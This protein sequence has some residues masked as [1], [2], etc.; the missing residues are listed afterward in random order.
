MEE[1]VAQVKGLLVAIPTPFDEND[2][3]DFDY[4]ARHLGFLRER[5]ADGVV[6]SGTNGEAAS[7]SLE[8][9]KRIIEVVAQHKGSLAAVAGT[10]CSSLVETIELTRAAEDSGADAAMVVPPFFFRNATVDG[11]YDY[12]AAVL[13]STA[14]PVYL[15]NIPALSGIEIREELVIRLLGF[16]NLAGI[17]DSGGD[18]ARTRRYI[19]AFPSL[20]IFYGADRIIEA[21]AGSGARGSISGIA[22][23]FPELISEAMTRC[24]AGTGTTLQERVN[25]LTYILDRY[26]LFAANKFVLSL[27]GFAY[28]RVRPPL[29]DLSHEQQERMERELRSEGY[30]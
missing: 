1:T 6:V 7:M 10:G 3:I 23:C 18:A 2:Q 15:Y 30:L 9:R 24:E 8:E 22:N 29:V 12:Y 5:G 11:L 27:R 13:G 21:M 14:L 19:E 25:G 26:P 28:T 17:K 20:D 4:V 16:A